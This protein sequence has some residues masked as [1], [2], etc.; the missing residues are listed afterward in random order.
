MHVL[1][2]DDDEANRTVMCE[3]IKLL[4]HSAV[5]ARDRE[6]ALAQMRTDPPRVAFIDLRLGGDSGL[7]VARDRRRQEAK[8]NLPRVSM[9]GL[10]GDATDEAVTACLAAGVDD[11][12]FKPIYLEVLEAQLGKLSDAW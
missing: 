11:C 7:D 1:V 8:E 2:V 6:S 5:G 12:L 9:F 10:T 3:L 4:N